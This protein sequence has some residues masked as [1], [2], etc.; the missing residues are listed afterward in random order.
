VGCAHPVTFHPGRGDAGWSAV[1]RIQRSSDPYGL[2]LIG[3]SDLSNRQ[4]MAAALDAV[5]RQQPDPAVPIVIDVRDLRFADAATGVLLG[6]L[7]RRAPAGI[8]LTECST[9]LETVLER[10]GFTRLPAIRLTRA[11]GTVAG[12]RNTEMVG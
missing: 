4:A 10:L 3:E 2:R 1:L 6:R 5:L 11:R 8:H 9:A 7:A 12:G